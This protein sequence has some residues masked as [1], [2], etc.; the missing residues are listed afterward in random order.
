[1]ANDTHLVILTLLL[2][3]KVNDY[4]TI[5]KWLDQELQSNEQTISIQIVDDL[6]EDDA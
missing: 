3:K 6:E 1:M 5:K 4:A 2:D